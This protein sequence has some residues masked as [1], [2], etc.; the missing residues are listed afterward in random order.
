[1][2]STNQGRQKNIQAVIDHQNPTALRGL[3]CLLGRE[4][5]YRDV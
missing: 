1:M 2:V 5:F 3:R 4:Q